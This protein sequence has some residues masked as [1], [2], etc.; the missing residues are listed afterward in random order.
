MG[1]GAKGMG[2]REVLFV[3]PFRL[4]LCL[5]PFPYAPCPLPF[6]QLHLYNLN[7]T[8]LMSNLT[9]FSPIRLGRYTLPN[10]I[11]MAPLTRNRAG[12]GNVPGPLNATYYAQR[13]SAGLII[14]EAT[15]FHPRELAIPQPPVFTHPN[16]SL[17]GV[18]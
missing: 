9:L 7:H 14:T 4:P 15:R 13:A 17:D 6:A 16:R 8:N 2:H 1:H 18:W 5:S 3:L 10:R 11:V 12:A